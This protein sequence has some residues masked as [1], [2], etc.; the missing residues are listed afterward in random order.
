MK[1]IIIKEHETIPE[2]YR[3]SL[4]SVQFSGV[5]DF[6]G[7]PKFLG[8]DSYFRASYFVGTCSLSEVFS[9]AVLPKIKNIDF[10][11]MFLSALEVDSAADYFS[12]CYRI[13]FDEPAIKTPD[14]LNVL[15]PL[16]VLHFISLTEKLVKR[17]LK[18]GYIIR[19]ENLK[20]K[21]KGKIL[22][23]EHLHQNIF[24]KREDRIF[25]R[26]QEYTFDIPENRLLK[27]ALLF[28]A[29]F[30]ETYKTGFEN[31]KKRLLNLQQKFAGVSDEIEVSQIQKITANKLFFSYK[32][33]VKIAKMIL[34]RFDYSLR[35]VK[36]T[37]E[38][39]PF[40]IDMSRLF[41]LYV[42]N[43]LGGE[44][45]NLRF[46][47]HGYSGVADFLKIDEQIVIDTKYKPDYGYD[48]QDIRQLSG[49]ARDRK[50]L[51][52]LNVADDREIKCLIIYPDENGFLQL[53]DDLISECIEIPQF[54]NFYKIS[55]K[56]PIKER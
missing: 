32:S 38:N 37:F 21:I 24:Q 40:Y 15:S 52:V 3:D 27:K 10:I 13:Y 29:K 33:A 55:V 11:K 25:C 12:K 44:N 50:I 17:G 26:F 46:Q 34:R 49:Y 28:C 8:I 53:G 23:A 30:L 39:P 19:E 5:K 42:L 43:L 9:V 41:E 18:R 4:K 6:M 7:E 45:E 56:L 22:W 20:S 31:V 47:V 14:S 48:R 51:S 54:R 35:N 1:P 2:E 16:L 36:E